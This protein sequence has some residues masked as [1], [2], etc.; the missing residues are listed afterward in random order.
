MIKVG[1]TLAQNIKRKILKTIGFALLLMISFGIVLLLMITSS[2]R[3]FSYLILA[4]CVGSLVFLRGKTF[5]HGWRVLFCWAA[6]LIVAWISLFAGQPSVDIQPTSAK[7]EQPGTS[8]QL[9]L[10]NLTIVDTRTGNLTFNM[11]ILCA[12]GKITNIAPIGT[13][14]AD[15]NTKI[16]DATGKYAVPGYLNMHM[17]VIGEKST[18]ESMDLL[19][20]NG[21]TGFRQMSGSYELLK[22][23]HS[24]N[25]TSSTDQPALLTMPIDIMTPMNAPTP[26][27]AIEFVRQQQK[28]G[29][30]FIKVGGVS[31]DVFNA[32][33]TEANK[34]NIPVEGHVLPDMD[35]KEVSK[36]GIHSVEHFGINNGALISCSTDEKAL[37]E[38]QATVIPIAITENPIFV[39]LMKIKGLQNFVNEQIIGWATKSSGGAKDETQLK[40]IINTYSEEKAKELADVYVQ[41]NTWQC[42]TMVRIYSGL[43]NE[44]SEATAQK[45]YDLYL[46][47]VKTYDAEGVKMIIGTD[48]NV[49]SDIHR[50]FDELEKADI[51]PLHVLQMTTLNG[52]EFLKRLDDMGTIEVGKNA[53]LVLLDA[54]PI[55]S[56]QNLHKIDAVIRAGAYHDKEELNMIKDRFGT[57]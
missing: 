9:L 37:R 32:A 15:E 25:F 36:D 10:N 6:A 39:Q 42:P 2:E 55:E 35:L 52:A 13:I 16:I 53:D 22:E 54:N 1:N 56:V 50:E 19:L 7:L 26:K 21:I 23:W 29:A 34:L 20:A 27:I 33:Q 44:S 51:S 47:L 3:W 43:F 8:Y 18:S 48:G 5:W 12:N 46:K 31:P 30:E 17:H 45:L 11:S 28:E 40:H 41:Y 57:K 24:G 4:A 49:G 14:Q 38:Q